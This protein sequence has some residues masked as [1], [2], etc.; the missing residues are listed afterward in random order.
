MCTILLIRAHSI[1][2]IKSPF[3]KKGVRVRERGK[4]K[5]IQQKREVSFVG[6]SQWQSAHK[7]LHANF[8]LQYRSVVDKFDLLLFEGMDTTFC[9]EDFV[10]SAECFCTVEEYEVMVG[11]W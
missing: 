5:C 3:N 10:G 9:S 6:F 11:T 7:P 8:S 2:A 4:G 1:V